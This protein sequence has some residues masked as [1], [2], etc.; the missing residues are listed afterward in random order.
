MLNRPWRCAGATTAGA[1]GLCPAGTY[2]TGSG[3]PQRM[4]SGRRP[5][6]ELQRPGRTHTRRLASRAEGGRERLALGHILT[7]RDPRVRG[8]SLPR[9]NLTLGPRSCC[10]FFILLGV[11]GICDNQVTVSTI[12]QSSRLQ[13]CITSYSRSERVGP[14]STMHTMQPRALRTR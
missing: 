7:R 12:M 2:Q 4:W 10:D 8:S 11:A 3:P 9:E 5:L 1:C 13:V 6:D 14:T